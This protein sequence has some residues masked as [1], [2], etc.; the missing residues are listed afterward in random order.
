MAKALFV[1][2]SVVADAN[3]RLKFD[4]WY[5]VDHL[6][7]ALAGFQAEKAWRAWSVTDPSVHYAYYQFPDLGT[8]EARLKSPE[9]RVLVEDYD[10]SFPSGV[11]RAREL[12]VL[13]DEGVV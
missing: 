13:A 11:A 12:L 1:V 6:P 5:A 2:R 9:F 3:L 10:R 7:R 8:L 4:P